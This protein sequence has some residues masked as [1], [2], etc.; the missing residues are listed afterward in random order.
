MNR[1]F[2]RVLLLAA[3]TGC[4]ARRP[5]VIV[6]PIP[7]SGWDIALAQ[8]RRLAM[9][10]APAAADSVLVAFASDHLGSSDA[11]ESNYW[12]ALFRLDPKYGPTGARDALPLL[13][14]YLASD[15]ARDHRSEATALKHVAEEV[16]QLNSVIATA[17]GKAQASTAA[18]VDA[19]ADVRSVTTDA[20]LQ[21]AEIHRLRDE[22]AKANDELDRIKKRLAEVQK[23]P[24]CCVGPPPKCC[25]R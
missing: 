11:M 2:P 17:T 4:L 3:A 14:L 15:S 25:P 7:D 18:A 22:L 21:D 20:Q 13:D 12:R 24:D 1:I 6:A 23:K 10:G 5:P 8:A 9:Q 16:D 19:R